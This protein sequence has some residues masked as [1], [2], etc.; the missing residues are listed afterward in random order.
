M[1]AGEVVVLPHRRA[2]QAGDQLELL[3]EQ[4]EALLRERDPVRGVL[5]REPAGAEAQLDPAARHLVHLRH[6]DREHTGCR[7]VADETRVPSRMRLVSRASPASVVQESVG[8]G[9]PSPPP[10]RR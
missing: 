10:I 2:P 3:R 9:R 6:L 8:P 5:L 4:A 7:N 1:L